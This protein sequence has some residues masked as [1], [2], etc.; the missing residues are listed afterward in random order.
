[1]RKYVQIDKW[2]LAR[3]MKKIGYNSVQRVMKFDEFG[4]YVPF[5]TVVRAF[6]DE[7]M[8]GIVW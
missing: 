6:K 1:M 2:T 3:M 5:G 8:E 7:V 4:I